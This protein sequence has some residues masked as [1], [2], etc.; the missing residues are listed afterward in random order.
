[1]TEIQGRILLL[2]SE[3][4]EICRKYNI[5]YYLEGGSV[6]GAIR[7]GGFLPWDDDADL[8]MTRKNWE[9]FRLAMEKE[10]PPQ[11]VLESPEDNPEYPTVTMRYVDTSTTRLWRS[12]M[13]DICACGVAIDIFVLEGAPDDKQALKTMENNL[14]DYCE[15]VN[16]Y[17]RISSLGDSARYKHL[18]WLRRFL[19]RRHVAG[20]LNQRLLQYDEDQCNRYLMRWGFRFQVYDKSIFGKPVYVPFE[21]LLLPVP[22]RVYEYLDYQYGVDWYMVPE[23]DH[24]D[25]HDTVL[26]MSVSYKDYVKKYMPLINKHQAMTINQRYKDLEMEVL[27]YS[28]AY[29]RH[30][31]SV[32]ANAVAQLTNRTCRANEEHLELWFYNVSPEADEHLDQLFGNYLEKQ[33]NEWFLFFRVFVPLEDP[34]LSKLL[35]YL[36]RRGALR[37]VEKIMEI[38]REQKD[39]LTWEL[40]NVETALLQSKQEI[41][42]FWQGKAFVP[43]ENRSLVSPIQ[44]GAELCMTLQSCHGERLSELEIKVQQ[45]LNCYPYEDMFKLAYWLLLRRKGDPDYHMVGEMLKKETRNGM[46][47]RWL[48]QYGEVAAYSGQ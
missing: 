44:L 42:N 8:A 10:S 20:W 36:F 32:T 17:Y 45:G 37:K 33:L 2:L 21:T 4:D 22:E 26:D 11:R 30:I 6:L 13:L 27:P 16:R 28:Q 3:I 47:L 19:G 31:Y 41:H 40:Q 43:Q 12:L 46:L 23:E 25:T 7:H 1:M 39:P 38:R 35:S 34:Y 9:K 5:E 18:K 14:I 24:I 15:F 29:H 48:T